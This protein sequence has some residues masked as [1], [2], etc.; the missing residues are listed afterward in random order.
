[1]RSVPTPLTSAA[2]KYGRLAPPRRGPVMPSSPGPIP[3]SSEAPR[4]RLKPLHVLLPFWRVGL[5]VQ[6]TGWP[7]LLGNHSA[8]TRRRHTMAEAE[9][10]GRKILRG[11]VTAVV[12]VAVLVL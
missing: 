9:G 5:P 2:D 6:S 10:G 4:C 1:M 11:L 7:W 8:S 3:S 12:A